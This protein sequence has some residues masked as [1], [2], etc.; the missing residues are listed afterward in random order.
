MKIGFDYIATIG[1]GGNSR[2]SSNL[3][4][5]L[6]E[7]DSDNAYYLYGFFH[8][9]L[10]GK[11]D[12]ICKP[13][14]KFMPG[15][16]SALGL[17]IQSACLKKINQISINLLTQT[18][19]I[20]IFHFTNPLNFIYGISNSIVTIHDLAPLYNPAWVKKDTS[21][22]F[23]A[24]I[25]SI[26][27]DAS[28]IIAVSNFT[29]E[30]IIK[31]FN[32]DGKKIRVIYEAA[33][34]NFYPDK[35]FKYIAEKF[36]IDNYLLCAGELQPRKNIIK[37]L[38]AYSKLNDDLRNEYKLV[39]AGSARDHFFSESVVKYISELNLEKDVVCLGRVL[40]ND[41]RKLYS[42]AKILVCPSLFE[43]FG[44]PVAESIKCGTPAAVSNNSS[45]PEVAG[46][47][48]ILFD[49]HDADN[50]K[51]VIEKILSDENLYIA[52]K[53]NCAKQADKFTWRKTAEETLKVYQEILV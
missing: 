31:R 38:L 5:S 10:R 17:P 28:I 36:G 21:D 6:S 19:R 26:L 24:N 33:D 15:Y 23:N 30:D 48:G 27:S 45:L 37:L 46:S 49:P 8:D 32:L 16:F 2:Y 3:I 52:L 22:W 35:D 51:I 53:K 29:K 43:G 44:L 39:L 47:A 9:Y 1:G 25:A 40:D 41:L 13:N 7:I 34:D 11:K 50:I 20:Q 14:F 18:H 4:K 42:C 12:R